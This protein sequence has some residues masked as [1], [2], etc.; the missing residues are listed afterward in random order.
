MGRPQKPIIAA[1]ALTDLAQWL[2]TRRSECH[3]T[4][5]EMA[6]LSGIHATTLQRAAAG[7]S[8]PRLAVVEKYSEVC[9][10]DLAVARGLWRAARYEARLK[11]GHPADAGRA[12]RPEL[13]R[14]FADLVHLM[15]E[16]HL[17]A[18]APSLRTLQRNAGK[19]GQLPRSTLQRVLSGHALPSFDHLVAFVEGCGVSRDALRAWQWAW[20]RAERV[21][22][23]GEGA[24]AV[25]RA[26]L[27]HELRSPLISVVGF[28]SV[29]L[30]KWDR[31]TGIQKRMMVEVLDA[32]ARRVSSLLGAMSG[33]L[34]R[35]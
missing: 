22:R 10:A 11:Q 14:D 26:E 6:C 16:L 18:G 2:R 5:R 23:S 21:R 8:V 13:V 24:E 25:F 7:A 4:Y 29:L 20:Q 19:H 28:S 3:L 15:R 35:D 27:L 32:D 34:Y 1:P 17:R 9:Q 31:F 33:S 30:K 12:L